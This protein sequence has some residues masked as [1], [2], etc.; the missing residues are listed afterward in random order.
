GGGN[1]EEPAYP[2]PLPLPVPSDIID[3]LWW[4]VEPLPRQRFSFRASR[5]FGLELIAHPKVLSD[6]IYQAPNVVALTTSCCTRGAFLWHPRPLPQVQGA[7]G[8][9]GQ[10]PPQRRRTRDNDRMAAQPAGR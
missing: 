9:E 4:L 2:I 5:H 7:K 1:R 8:H 10:L 6:K 3:H